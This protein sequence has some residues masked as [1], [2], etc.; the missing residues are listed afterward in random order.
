M[1]TG[2]LTRGPCDKLKVGKLE[3]GKIRAVPA[4]EGGNVA[5]QASLIRERLGS[6]LR[7]VDELTA[8]SQPAEQGQP[9]TEQSVRALLRLRRNRDRFFSA[10]LFADPAW[11]M[12]LELY[13][14]ELGQQR[15]SISSLCLGSAVPATTALRWITT[16][17]QEKLVERRPDPTDGRRFFIQLTREGRGAMDSYFMTVPTDAAVI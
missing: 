13:A 14:C 12:L 6:A 3:Q 15:I 9:M 7:L 8:Q 11:D 17:E 4:D 10:Q 5:E 1:L 16:L 2:C